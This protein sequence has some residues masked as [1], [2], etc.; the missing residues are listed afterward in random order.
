ME[1]RKLGQH[2]MKLLECL[3]ADCS[4][5]GASDLHLT[6]NERPYVRRV[7]GVNPLDIEPTSAET[8]QSIVDELLT[9]PQQ[10]AL[11]AERSIDVS[12]TAV[13]KT[14]FRLNIFFQRGHLAIAIRR[15]NGQTPALEELELPHAIRSLADYENGLIIATG[16]TG[17]GKST[18]LATMIDHIN[19]HRNV[20][21]ITI[22]DPI[23]YVHE[24][25]RALVHQREVLTDA[26]SFAEALRSALREDPDVLLVGEMRDLATIRTALV[27]AETG[28][29]VLS[30]LHTGDAIGAIGR[31]INAFPG[32]EHDDVRKRLSDGLKAV[33]AQTLIP[34]FDGQRRVPVV[35]I[36]T[37]NNAVAN[38]IR[39]G[40]T[41]Q[42][43]SVM[44]TATHEGMRI[45]EQALAELTAR[46]LITLQVAEH[47][48]RNIDILRSRIE[49]LAHHAATS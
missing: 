39:N 47:N 46:G 6:T 13:D 23:E 42:I 14:R 1:G 20:H 2:A 10:S 40:E 38:L 43:L 28:H 22:E 31:I 25:R 49:H 16:A 36:L 27:A 8:L 5:C 37:V 44:Q 41:N 19:T 35:E 12:Y 45:Q 18:T 48:A 33:I 17:S 26:P 11:K 24:N 30:T 21:I 4:A 15:L 32:Y 7:D 34:A 29:L 9:T 3:L